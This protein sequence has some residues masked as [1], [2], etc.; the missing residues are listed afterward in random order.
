MQIGEAVAIWTSIRDCADLSLEAL[1]NPTRFVLMSFPSI[2][3]AQGNRM[4][5]TN[6]KMDVVGREFFGELYQHVI[7]DRKMPQ[8]NVMGTKGIG[9]SYRLAA[10]VALLLKQVCDCFPHL[11]LSSS[12]FHCWLCCWHVDCYGFR[13]VVWFTCPI[14]A[15]R[16]LKHWTAICTLPFWS[17]LVTI[18]VHRF[19]SKS[20]N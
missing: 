12:S 20:L 10:L 8:V 14:A 7:T 9:K 4:K 18:P 2:L 6:G 3:I 1:S 19:A 16:A 5:L 11:Q 17:L 15:R 13:V